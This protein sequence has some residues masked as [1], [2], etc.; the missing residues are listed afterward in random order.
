VVHGVCE[1]TYDDPFAVASLQPCASTA[2]S[3]QWGAIGGA[4]VHGSAGAPVASLFRRHTAAAAAG[5]AKKRRRSGAVGVRFAADTKAHDGLLPAHEL[6]D[7]LV[8]RHVAAQSFC[9][10]N[11]VWDF[12]CRLRPTDGVQQLGAVMELVMDLETRLMQLAEATMVPLDG[13][14]ELL[15][16]AAAVLG[17]EAP[18]TPDAALAGAAGGAGDV[19]VDVDVDVDGGDGGW[20]VDALLECVSVYDPA[21]AAVTT[22]GGAVTSSASPF[23]DAARGSVAT[24]CAD[25][26]TADASGSGAA[27]PASQPRRR[28]GVPVLRGGGGSCARLSV[29]ALPQLRQL[30]LWLYQ[31]LQRVHCGGV[32]V[33]DG[34]ARSWTGE[35]GAEECGVDSATVAATTQVTV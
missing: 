35:C 2:P 24:V 15:S 29:E 33:A 28:D 5:V 34:V 19:A 21:T 11:D 12:A 9:S 10:A 31:C 26:E 3:T 6:F 25:G 1:R 23:Q 22:M 14:H 30:S 27:V 8:V 17:V 18:S 13:A 4:A 32:M 16:E 7:G 20:S